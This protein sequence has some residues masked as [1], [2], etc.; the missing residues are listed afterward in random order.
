MYRRLTVV[1]RLLAV[2]LV[3]GGAAATLSAQEEAPISVI[4]MHHSTGEGVIYAGGVVPMMTELGYAFQHH[5]YNGDGLS[6]AAGNYTGVNWNVPG[7]NTD[8]DGWQAIFN[9]PVTDP[10]SNTF[11]HMLQYDVIIFK[12]CFPAS[13]IDSPGMFD[14]YMAYYAS[15]R[16]VM[17]QHPDKLFIPWTT[18]PL[19][20]NST[21]AASAQRAQEWAAYLTSDEYLDGHPNIYPFD[22]NSLW[23]DADG[24]L[25]AEFRVDEWD[26]HPNDIGNQVVA[27]I[28]VDFIDGAVQSFLHGEDRPV[29]PDVTD[30]MI[31]AAYA[32][33]YDD[34][35][36][37]ESGADDTADSADDAAAEDCVLPESGAMID[38][39]D[40]GEFENIWWV[41]IVPEDGAFACGPVDDGYESDYALR[42]A[43]DLPVDFYTGCGRMLRPG[44]EWA[45]SAGFAFMWRAEVP[46]QILSV[47]MLVEDT[48]FEVF[49]ETEGEDWTPV[50]LLWE[51]FQRAEWAD[52]D[53]PDVFD[54]SGVT[55][56]GFSVGDWEAPLTGTIWIDDLRLLMPVAD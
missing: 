7:D 9:Q 38:G 20:P 55:D 11:S 31:A 36:A 54:P 18:P 33:A 12:S 25:R 5:G 29:L 45:D 24:Y 23:A 32:G 28:F 17:D 15:I 35:A 52:A 51:E 37:D 8:P 48:P 2:C 39:F 47:I 4:F 22:I 44:A 1:W 34:Y 16:D 30:E 14:A 19:V 41:D 21:D 50:M 49:I 40:D 6:D 3:I 27:P 10:P 43:Y 46:G 42:L 26:S 56:L 53:G 13:H